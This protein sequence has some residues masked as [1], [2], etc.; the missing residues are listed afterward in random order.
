MVATSPNGIAHGYTYRP[1]WEWL[2]CPLPEYAGF[3][4]EVQVN[5]SFGTLR[6]DAAL[7]GPDASEEELLRS[8]AKRCRAWN[9][10]AVDSDGN[11]V[12]IPSPG[13]AIGEDAW[14]AFYA[15]E[16]GLL[17]WLIGAIRSAHL[18]AP[19]ERGK[20]STPFVATPTPSSGDGSGSA[21]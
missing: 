3:R 7:S 20:G 5:P 19:E 15:L 12:P 17:L 10:L 2:D 11:E 16:R 13:D 18:G 9:A 6:E 21:A 1:R 4:A 8:L 14:Q